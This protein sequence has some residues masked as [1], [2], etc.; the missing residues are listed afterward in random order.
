[1]K[2]SLCI[3]ALVA[4]ALLFGSLRG[5]SLVRASGPE[6]YAA[7]PVDEWSQ[8]LESAE[9]LSQESGKPILILSLNEGKSTT[10]TRFNKILTDSPL[11]AEVIEEE[12]H[13]VSRLTDESSTLRTR[14]STPT[15][16]GEEFSKVDLAQF[17]RK[18]LVAHGKS[19][20]G[21]LSTV[22]WEDSSANIGTV[23]FSMFCFWTGEQKLGGIPGVLTTEAGWLGGAEVTRVTFDRTVLPFPTLLAE[24]QRFDCA[25]S[26]FTAN[27]EDAA[28]ARNSR[29]STG[30]FPADYRIASRPDQKRQL[31]GTAFAALRLNPVQATKVNAFARSQPGKALE[32]LSPSQLESLK[33]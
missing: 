22:G 9:K 29:L 24:A 8:S 17:L 1:M 6:P 3:F 33:R 19:V 2:A 27:E 21:Y 14:G 11:L 7:L 18:S 23:A 20:P 32:W 15:A 26:V 30:S 5:P 12:F 13:P 25:R 28:V 16:V 10:K 31:P 4:I